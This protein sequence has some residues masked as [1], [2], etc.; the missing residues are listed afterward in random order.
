MLKSQIGKII[1]VQI[2]LYKKHLKKEERENFQ[3]TIIKLAP[4]K[5]TTNLL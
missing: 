1:G 4:T 5:K 2:N 3:R